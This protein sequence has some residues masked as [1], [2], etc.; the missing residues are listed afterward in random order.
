M[1]NPHLFPADGGAVNTN[2]DSMAHWD[3][4]RLAFTWALTRACDS[5]RLI[6][7]GACGQAS[8]AMST[9]LSM[10]MDTFTFLVNNFGGHLFKEEEC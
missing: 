8:H 6:A 1:F 4:G 7:A 5:L 2:S 3:H 10:G 9:D